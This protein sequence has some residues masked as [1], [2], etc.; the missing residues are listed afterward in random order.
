[1][2]D[3]TPQ[4]D[5]IVTKKDMGPGDDG[6]FAYWEAQ[7]AIAE[8]E[9]QAWVKKSREIV[10]RYR[11]ERDQASNQQSGSRLNILWSNVQTLIPTLFART[12]KP[13]VKRRFNDRDPVGRLASVLLERCIAF[14]A[15]SGMF[16]SSMKSC[17]QDK[18][19]PGRGSVRILYV[20][21]FGDPLEEDAPEG[22]T[23]DSDDEIGGDTA[24]G[25]QAQAPKGDEEKE[26]PLRE[27]V[28]EEVRFAYVFWEDYQES[29]ARQWNE[30]Y[31]IRFRSFMTRDELC[32]R[33]GRKKGKEVELDYT[34][35][36]SHNLNKSNTPPDLYKKALVYEVW[37]KSQLKVIWYAPGTPGLILDE[38][39][40]PLHL[41]GFYPTPDPLLATTTNDKRIP[42]PDY[43]E[44]RDQAHQLDVLTARIDRLL[45]ALKVSGVYPGEE[46]AV[47]Q[48]LVDEGTENRLIP[49]E[50]WPA[51]GDKGS[52]QQFIQWMPIK[53][54]AETL[55]QLYNARDRQK[56]LLYE[57]TGLS[58]I[59]RGQTSPEET[60]GA[61]E[62]KANFATRRITP[63]QKEVARYAR[64][65]FRLCGAVVAEHFDPK[66]ISLIT[67]YPQLD[68]VPQLPPMPQ[69]S[70]QVIAWVVGAQK[71]Q[72][73]I[74]KLPAPA[75][76][77]GPAGGPPPPAVGARSAPP[78]ASGTGGGQAA[79]PPYV[80]QYQQQLMQFQQMQAGVQQI[81]QQNQAKQKAFD[82]AI[83]LIKS[84]GEFGFHIDI[85]ADSTIAPDEQQEKQ[86]RMEFLTAFV[87][88]MEKAIPFSMGNPGV[89]EMIKEITLFAVRGFKVAR[90]LEDTIEKAFD[91]LSKMPPHPDATGQ[92][93]GGDVNPHGADPA[94][95]KLR[96][97]DI[98]SK[99]QIAQINDAT[100]RYDIDQKTKIAS[101]EAGGKHAGDVAKH[102][103]EEQ[104]HRDEVILKEAEMAHRSAEKLE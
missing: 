87:P 65:L 57:I 85:E 16:E 25:E 91:G 102:G 93:P 79:P 101:I 5:R 97:A 86:S 55:I 35:R 81:Q 68:P 41:P 46:K 36:G 21:H 31:W 83:A 40:D 71:A 26:E 50:D 33:F 8:R 13:D 23:K 62:L 70:P 19:L 45:R 80:M 63:Q 22:G 10:K 90:T 7:E 56:V 98:Q 24:E 43:S 38:I 49:V 89:A 34:P 27:V 42:V 76:G 53:E 69:P 78:Q 58:D 12:P 103:L 61:Q 72:E 17:V 66:T 3:A 94:E 28:Y 48:Q 74:K 44:Y 84:D 67:G 100:K 92:Q 59:L 4:P 77:V 32:T 54:V 39:D 60:L 20:P 15:D 95:L 82:D 1:M 52:L 11:D 73:D 47:L 64:D 88:F 51:W 6:K 2:V 96:Q 9:E 75:N 18:L 30:V 14:Q 37:D 99:V 104:K 29:P